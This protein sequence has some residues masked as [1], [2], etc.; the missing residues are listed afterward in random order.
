MAG[1]FVLRSITNSDLV[2]AQSKGCG[3]SGLAH[4]PGAQNA[5]GNPAHAGWT[6]ASRQNLS[7]AFNAGVPNR[8]GLP[9]HRYLTFGPIANIPPGNPLWLYIVGAGWASQLVRP[10]MGLAA[11]APAATA[12]WNGG[13]K[14]GALLAQAQHG[15]TSIE[16]YYIG[17]YEM[18]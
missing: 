11:L 7:A 18:S 14:D 6:I 9:P 12:A 2:T 3:W 17:G 5:P 4:G 13:D 1:H 8:N 10:N 15:N 16:I